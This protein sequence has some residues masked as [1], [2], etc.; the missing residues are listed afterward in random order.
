M[1][2]LTEKRREK[3][4]KDARKWRATHPEKDRENK[5][6]WYADHRESASK[7]QRARNKCRYGLL[8]GDYESM[9]DMQD[10]RC[11]VCGRGDRRL[12]IDHNH[13]TGVVRGLLC[14]GCNTS[15]GLLNDSPDLLQAAIDY[16]RGG[17]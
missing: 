3:N 2:M 5:R 12:C 13:V 16:L 11:A 17:A 9:L 6:D 10:G 14:F 7:R 4:R 8:P 15:I 1:T